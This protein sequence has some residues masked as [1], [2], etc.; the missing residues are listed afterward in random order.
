MKILTV[1]GAGQGTSLV[2]RMN[3]QEVAEE[4]GLDADVENTDISS[5]R[6]VDADLIMAGDYHKSNLQDMEAP[7]YTL[8]D[9][10][11]KDEIREVLEKYL[12]EGE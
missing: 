11:D 3:I 7:V 6:S 1:C 8:E 4:I 9:F 5:A 10:M 2:L 12:A